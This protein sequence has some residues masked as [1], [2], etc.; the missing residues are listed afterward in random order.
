VLTGAVTERQ[1]RVGWQLLSKL[2]GV[3]R[4]IYGGMYFSAVTFHRFGCVVDIANFPH[5]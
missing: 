3:I 1:S 2:T 5:Y 4:E